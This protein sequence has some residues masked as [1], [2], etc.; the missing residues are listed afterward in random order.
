[1][2]SE[3]L[4]AGKLSGE[5]RYRI[6]GSELEGENRV[7]IDEL[8]LGE[9]PAG[10]DRFEAL[11]GLPLAVVASL[12]QGPD[13]EIRVSVPVR[14]DLRN[15]RFD[16]GDAIATAIRNA[17]VEVVTAPFRLIGQ[18]LTAGGRLGAIRIAPV[19]FDAGS[20]S[21]N[22]GAR[23]HLERVAAALRERPRV[24]VKL[25]GLAALA[26]D[27]EGPRESTRGGGDAPQERLGFTPAAPGPLADR[28]VTEQ[29]LRALAQARALAVYDALV[30]KDI[31][32]NRLFLAE[33]RVVAP[34]EA[35]DADSRRADITILSSGD[36]F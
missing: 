9:A 6:Q 17:I 12:L 33:G 14:G 18:V 2:T 27:G 26:G 35:G 1:V 24:K 32:S 20:A 31:A 5:L 11:V 8:R 7:R 15:P 36:P 16:F 22:A 4:E 21:L 30:A 10:E 19:H 25:T 28:P 3:E 29:E 34:G 13:G 23:E